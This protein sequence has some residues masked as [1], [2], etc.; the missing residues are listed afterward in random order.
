MPPLA[1]GVFTAVPPLILFSPLLGRAGST[2]A[3]GGDPFLLLYLLE[4]GA[5]RWPH[6]LD[7]FWQAP[8]FFPSPL[9]TTLS[10]HMLAPAAF[11]GLL[12]AVGATPALGYNLMLLS[13]FV[14]TAVAAYFLLR[15]A[16]RCPPW[17]ATL[18]AVAVV[19]A[20]WRWGQI[21][22]LQ[23]LWAPGPLLALL[24][25]DR[26]LRRGRRRDL[27]FFLGAYLLTMLSGCYLA[28]YTLIAMAIVS[29][30]HLWRRRGRRRLARRW[31]PLGAS[32]IACVLIASWIF[33]PYLEARDILE[34][35]RPASEI[36][37][38]GAR[39]LDWLA[40]STYQL[41][42]AWL[43]QA[44][45]HAERDLFPGLLL[46]VGGLA[47]LG[48]G[49][50]RRRLPV[51]TLL[52]RALLGVGVVFLVLENANVYL[53]V[54][55]FLPGLDGMRVPTRG[56]F[57]VLLAFAVLAG[58]FLRVAT[59]RW[60]RWR[61][62]LALTCS[63]LLLPELAVRPL[64]DGNFFQPDDLDA[65]PPHIAAIRDSDATAIAVLD[66]A[67]N[68]GDVDHM[69]RSFA[70]GKKIA[71]GFSGYLPP[72]FRYLRQECRTRYQ[73]LSGRC[74]AALRELGISHVVL[75]DA[76][77]QLPPDDL[78]ARLAAG[79]D[80][81]IRAQ[82]EVAFSDDEALLIDVR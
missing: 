82:V 41:D 57:F 61:L 40:P 6:A 37:R 23:M 60:P 64:S 51:A 11:Y 80:D 29:G 22:H 17:A 71:N 47:A 45:Q 7:G 13:A 20:P 46:A 18:L 76:H 55:R 38:F 31:L 72:T 56:H 26:V 65:L 74:V 33:L 48:F 43:P 8:F 25:F 78:A 53:F 44:W 39:P 4:W 67:G 24:F 59:R 66:L 63:V 10:D 70:H 79:V 9:S 81:E 69:W 21:T 73:P 68:F 14:F 77:L 35:Q 58:G 2:M 50:A 30:A 16:T 1:A 27:A 49:L 36:V 12:R 62:G 32:A 75:E 3:P 52:G 28:Y 34:A 54:A 15:Q 42:A 5:S 19:C